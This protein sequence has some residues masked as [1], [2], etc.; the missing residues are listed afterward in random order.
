MTDGQKPPQT[1]P[2]R[3][4]APDKNSRELRQTQL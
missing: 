1:K 4:N 2:S 3:Q